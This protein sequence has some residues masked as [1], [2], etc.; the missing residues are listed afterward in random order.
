MKAPAESR[1]SSFEAVFAA[2]VVVATFALGYGYWRLATRQNEQDAKIEQQRQEQQA[3]LTRLQ[4]EA[5]DKRATDDLEIQV[6]AL[7]SPHL[8]RLR[9][10]GREAATSQRIVA[11]AAE[12]LSSKGRPAL[13]QMAEKV[14]AE[15]API[16]RSGPRA[17]VQEPVAS[18]SPPGA[19]FVLLATLPGDD[20]K[21]AEGAANEKLRAARDVGTV[22]TVSIYKTRLKGRYVVVLGEPVGRSAAVAAAAEARRRNLSADAFAEADDGWELIGDAPFLTETRSASSNRET[23][24]L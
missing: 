15:S 11:A 22:S 1:P 17:T 3:A 2:Y 14:R 16:T 24:R 5:D 13:A 8:S 19:W 20:L 21:L 4:R 6:I 9:E 10:S 12:L 18:M 23:D 7:A